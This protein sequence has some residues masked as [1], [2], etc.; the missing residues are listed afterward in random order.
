MN[1]L[2]QVDY[3]AA[4]R[5]W[6]ERYGSYIA[7]AKNWRLMAFA[8]VG[9]A[10]LFSVGMI[11]EADRVHVVPYVVE[12]DH[13][14]DTVRMGQAIAAGAMDKPVITHLLANW[15][16]KTHERI[17]DPQAE[18]ITVMDT[19]KYVDQ[20]MTLALD[21]Y[22]KRHSPYNGMQNGPRTITIA[23]D[24][25]LGTPTAA[26]GTYQIKWTENQYSLKGRLVNEQHWQAIVQYAVLPVKTT[27]QAV[28]NPFGLY[29]TSFQWQQTL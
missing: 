22:Y 14:G 2:K 10:A 29:I 13:L 15:I 12:T 4:R 17:T 25:P 20:H 28:N 19:Y 7:S 21:R 6:M 1:E 8:S 9:I 24:M 5:E 27:A 16:V 3:Q 11:Y 26:G 18:K 23:S